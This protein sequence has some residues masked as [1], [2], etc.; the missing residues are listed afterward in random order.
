MEHVSINSNMYENCLKLPKCPKF[1]K[2]L[3]KPKFDSK[4][5][6]VDA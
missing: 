4:V 6:K 1:S 3:L 2:S 5:N